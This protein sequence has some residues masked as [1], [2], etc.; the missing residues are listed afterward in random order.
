MRII[1]KLKLFLINKFDNASSDKLRA[2]Y[3][4]KYNVEIGKYTYGYK[5]NDIGR[6]SVIGAFCSIASG[7]KIGLMNHPMQF[8]STNPFLYYKNRGF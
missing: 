8:V 4:K 6:D 2:Y 5:I 1:E 3:K 7:V